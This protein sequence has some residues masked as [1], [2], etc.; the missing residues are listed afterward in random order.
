MTK[1]R[2]FS[3]VVLAILIVGSISFY[4]V[5]GG[6]ASPVVKEET[7]KPHFVL[8][9]MHEGQDTVVGK[10]VNALLQKIQSGQVKG[11]PCI[12]HYKEPSEND[13]KVKAFVGIEV[14]DTNMRPNEGQVYLYL[15][16]RK[17]VSGYLKAMDAYV[18]KV[19][20]AM[21]DY[22]K[23]KELKPKEELVEIVKL[24]GG[25][26]QEFFFERPIE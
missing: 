15:K 25:M 4:G 3:I 18:P 10:A 1:K 19:Y 13:R 6:F 16:P 8:G 21:D 12:I 23:E 17:V 11:N 22:I 9:T 26:Q 7:S 24:S 20:Q 2:I 5:S 14:S